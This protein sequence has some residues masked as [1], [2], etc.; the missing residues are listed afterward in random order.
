MD[1]CNQCRDLKIGEKGDALSVNFGAIEN[2][3]SLGP[4][5]NS[6]A[7]DLLNNLAKGAEEAGACSSC[8]NVLSAR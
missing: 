4:P 3:I 1:F 7:P 2:I 8:L 6:I 5:F